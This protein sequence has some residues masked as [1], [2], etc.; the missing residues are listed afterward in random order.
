MKELYRTDKV[1]LKMILEKESGPTIMCEEESDSEDGL[2]VCKGLKEAGWNKK[3]RF[4]KCLWCVTLEI[5]PDIY[6]NKVHEIVEPN[7]ESC[8]GI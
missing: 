3:L 6:D 8:Q 1:K 7:I 5:E 4:E 2:F